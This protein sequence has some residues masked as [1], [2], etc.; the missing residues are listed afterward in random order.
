M[1]RHFSRPN[2]AIS[3][4]S[5]AEC[6]FAIKM[7]VQDEVDSIHESAGLPSI[8]VLM[9]GDRAVLPIASVMSVLLPHNFDCYQQFFWQTVAQLCQVY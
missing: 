8:L 2:T 5:I 3:F 9:Y 7:R 4:G 1:M 6:N